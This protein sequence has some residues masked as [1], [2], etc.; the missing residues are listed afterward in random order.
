MR[1]LLSPSAKEE[2]KKGRADE[3]SFFWARVD[4][5]VCKNCRSRTP[6]LYAKQVAAVQGYEVAF[7]RL[8]TQC[9]VR[10]HPGRSIH[11]ALSY[12]NGRADE[13]RWLCW[14]VMRIQR[15]QGSLH[16]DVL[17]S[18]SDC[19]V[20]YRRKKA[21]RDTSEAFTTL[22]RCVRSSFCMSCGRMTRLIE[23]LW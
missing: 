10:R 11:H 4:T 2:E 15:C 12:D 18:A 17:C 21:Q 13:R 22:E 23:G 5:A 14:A 1:D 9:Q 16:Q 8:W 3:R 20:F 6:E 19:V 7:S